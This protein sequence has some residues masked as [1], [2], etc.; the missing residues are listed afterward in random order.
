MVMKMCI[1]CLVEKDESAFYKQSGKGKTALRGMCKSCHTI[2]GQQWI[3]KNRERRRE[4]Y[5]V[6]E[7][8]PKRR[9]TRTE[10]Y[11][12]PT[13]KSYD[14]FRKI[15]QKYGLSEEEYWELY[16]QQSGACAIC[17]QIPEGKRLAVDHNHNSGSVRGLLC[18]GC[19]TALGHAKD[20]A[21]IL[22][23]MAEYLFKTR[24]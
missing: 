22:L 13:Y 24:R 16:E 23:K 1:K 18:Q 14:Y 15:D 7:A 9:A 11:K 17:G 2:L 19:N 12:S 3:E 10:T 20:N 8:N 21:N 6:Q 4:H 5:K